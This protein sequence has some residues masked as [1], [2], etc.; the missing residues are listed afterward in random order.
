M[1]QHEDYVAGPHRYWLHFFAGLGYGGLL[2]WWAATRWLSEGSY[3]LIATVLIAL[4]VAFFAGRW[5][6]IA[7]SRIADWLKTWWEAL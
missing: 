2:G 4:G 5:G 7:W 6:D 1:K 3:Q